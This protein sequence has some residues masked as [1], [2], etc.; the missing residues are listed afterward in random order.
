MATRHDLNVHVWKLIATNHTSFQLQTSMLLTVEVQMYMFCCANGLEGTLV[1]MLVDFVNVGYTFG[2]IFVLTKLM[3]W[4]N[5][6][7]KFHSITLLLLLLAST[8]K[9]SLIFCLDTDDHR[10]FTTQFRVQNTLK[11]D[12]SVVNLGILVVINSF[13][14]L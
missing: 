3:L 7:N 2:R 8:I 9:L 1:S 6:L 13:H 14:F 5:N 11:V 12:F 4:M 10:S